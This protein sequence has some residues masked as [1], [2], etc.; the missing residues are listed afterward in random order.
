MW[1][2][3]ARSLSSKCFALQIIYCEHFQRVNRYLSFE[4]SKKEFFDN[5]ASRGL[6]TFQNMYIQ[7]VTSESHCQT[8][9]KIIP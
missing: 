9:L 6:Y 8:I 5:M 2:R 7:F 4:T 1:P 3:V